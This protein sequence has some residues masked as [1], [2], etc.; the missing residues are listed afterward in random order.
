MHALGDLAPQPPRF[1]DVR[2]VYL[3]Q[4]LRALLRQLEADAHDALDLG[5]AVDFRVD[6]DPAA[7]GARLDAARLAE[8]NPAR[9]F[10]H[11]HQI[12]PGDEFGLEAGSLG[13][14]LETTA[15]R[16]LAKRSNSLRSRRMP[17]SGRSSN[18]S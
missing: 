7:V 8:I 15:G 1:H 10:A 12:E 6:A 4:P 11:D 13:E 3:A 5:F 18:G 14:R 9:Q 2:L 17:S 16:R